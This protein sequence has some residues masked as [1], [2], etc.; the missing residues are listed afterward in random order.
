M[1]ATGG[2]EILDP[3]MHFTILPDLTI[4]KNKGDDLCQELSMVPG[5][6]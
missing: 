6:L 2:S 4:R 1:D 5:V 3:I